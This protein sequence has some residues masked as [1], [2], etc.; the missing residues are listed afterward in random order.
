MKKLAII[1][2]VGAAGLLNVKPANAQIH[3]GL[4]L[5]FGNVGAHVVVAPP[6][7]VVNYNAYDN[8]D[9]FYY[10][11][12][13]EAYYDVAQQCYYYNDGEQWIHAAYLPGRFR[14]FDWRNARHYEVRARRPYMN[15][16]QYRTRFGGFDPRMGGYD[17][18]YANRGGF[19]H[20]DDNRGGWNGDNRGGFDHRDDNRGGWNGDNRNQQ[21]NRGNY[22]QP[23][24]NNGG[25]QNQGRGG[26]YGQSAGQNNGGQQNP[27]RGNGQ[28]QNNG[29]QGQDRGGN[30][31]EEHFAANKMG[32]M[33]PAR[34]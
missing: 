17:N 33:R 18:R 12:D 13:A 22:G 6:V 21:P 8:D 30:R 9:D 15:H 7:Q 34:F 3:L 23:Q 19:D 5:H 28:P 11:P 25:Q 26:N 1:L 20:R 2:A 32:M 4:N 24:Q 10:L 27:N 29:G 31:G 16:D 14:D